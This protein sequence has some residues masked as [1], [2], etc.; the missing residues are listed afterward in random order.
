MWLT[1]CRLRHSALLIAVEQFCTLPVACVVMC[2]YL[3]LRTDR[4]TCMCWYV[5]ACALHFRRCTTNVGMLPDWIM[6]VMDQF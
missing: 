4:R 1:A 6:R 5:R 3:Q 2:N